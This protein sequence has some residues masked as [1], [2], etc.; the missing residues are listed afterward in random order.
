MSKPL[1][2]TTILDGL[3]IPK[4]VKSAKHGLMESSMCQTN[5]NPVLLHCTKIIALVLT[6]ETT[7]THVLQK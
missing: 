2:L 6:S 4:Y 3:H 1:Y 7:I 5:K